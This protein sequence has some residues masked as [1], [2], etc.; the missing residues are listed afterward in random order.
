MIIRAVRLPV[1]TGGKIPFS[2]RVVRGRI[3]L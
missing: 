3:S 2:V 1:Q